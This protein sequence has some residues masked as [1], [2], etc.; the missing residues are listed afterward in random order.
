MLRGSDGGDVLI[1]MIWDSTRALPLI[2]V[3]EELGE[4]LCGGIETQISADLAALAMVAR[5]D[6]DASWRV[7]EIAGRDWSCFGGA[8]RVYWPGAARTQSPF[9]HQLW[10]R[11]RLQESAIS[12]EDAAS[13]LRRQ[14]RRIILA[15]SAFAIAPPAALGEIQHAARKGELDALRER[16]LSKERDAEAANDLFLRAAEM[17]EQKFQL[18]LENRR[19]CSEIERLNAER[20]GLIAALAPTRGD[21]DDIEPETEAPPD[22]LRAAVELAKTRLHTNIVLGEDAESGI[23]E[24]RD[25]PRAAEK[26]LQSLTVLAELSERLRNGPIGIDVLRW[27]NERG[28][29][30]SGE[31]ETTRNNKRLMAFRT[32]GDGTG[33]KQEFEHHLKPTNGVSPDRCI[34]IYFRYDH[35]RRIIVVGWIGRHP[36]EK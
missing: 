1:S 32:W 22:S 33:K 5:I 8:I 6:V 12:V 28:Q 23:P 19:L 34:R 35:G 2:V 26:L 3:S 21:E 31:S 16:L 14:L 10:T 11:S 36:P 27:L 13:R 30:A 25:E 18:E 29:R 4:V 17:E 15:Q 9:R 7:T 24:L 20:L